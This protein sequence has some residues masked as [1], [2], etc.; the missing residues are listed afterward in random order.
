MS[1]KPIFGQRTTNSAHSPV[2]HVDKLLQAAKDRAIA[3]LSPEDRAV[4]EQGQAQEQQRVESGGFPALD[5]SPRVSDGQSKRTI[6]KA[7]LDI[8]AAKVEDLKNPIV[9]QAGQ[10]FSMG[11]ED[12]AEQCETRR[13]NIQKRVAEMQQNAK[14]LGA[15]TSL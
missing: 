5:R 1:D 4:Y 11:G 14:Q 13:Q 12:I 9:P 15:G 10:G 3:S 8:I 6:E 2:S 7:Y